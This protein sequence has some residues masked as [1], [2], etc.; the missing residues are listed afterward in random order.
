M[1]FVFLAFLAGIVRSQVTVHYI[2]AKNPLQR[3]QQTLQCTL[4]SMLTRLLC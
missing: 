3:P 1:R 4:A 2:L